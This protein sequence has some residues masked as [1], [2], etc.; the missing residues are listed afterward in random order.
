MLNAEEGVIEIKDIAFNYPTK[1]DVQ[2]LKR[3]NIEVKN[4]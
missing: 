3:I 2:V 1:P 4:C